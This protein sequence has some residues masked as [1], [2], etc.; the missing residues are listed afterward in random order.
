MTSPK[1][2]A[3]FVS[4]GELLRVAL[5]QRDMIARLKKKLKDREDRLRW[6]NRRAQLGGVEAMRAIENAAD[7]KLRSP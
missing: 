2:R 1:R 4:T 3:R 7:L 6:I 5:I